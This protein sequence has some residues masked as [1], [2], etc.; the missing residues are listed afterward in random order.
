MKN[1]SKN[2]LE[3]LYNEQKLNP[4]EIGQI[5]KCNHKT[6]RRYLK[7][8]KISMRS[9]SEYNYLARVSHINPDKEIF[10]SKKSV[11]AHIAFLCEG[12]HTEKTNHF[13]FCNTD[14]NLCDLIIDCLNNT[15]KVG[16]IRLTIQTP[17]KEAAKYLKE[18]Y[19]KAKIRIERSRKT[20]ILRIFSGG[21]TLA[22]DFIKNAYDILETLK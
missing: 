15:Y 13:Y 22:R 5:L 2:E 8:H 14:P 21:K 19:P 10:M 1:I 3:T 6:V 18:L 12:W 16:T 7:L 20:P 9:A 11:A 17:T 4:Y